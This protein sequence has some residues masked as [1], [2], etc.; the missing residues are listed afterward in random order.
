MLGTHID[1]V[2]SGRVSAPSAVCSIRCSRRAESNHA[3]ARTRSTRVSAEGD[4][5]NV[6]RSAAKSGSEATRAF[7]SQRPRTRSST[8]ERRL[9]WSLRQTAQQPSK[10]PSNIMAPIPHQGE[11]AAIPKAW[12]LSRERDLQEIP[13]QR[14]PPRLRQVPKNPKFE[15]SMFSRSDAAGSQPATGAAPNPYRP[16]RPDRDRNTYEHPQYRK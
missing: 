16:D 5:V 13:G 4:S 15:S 1:R 7:R 3:R 10:P 11:S 9:H 12:P 6:I 14:V 8:R 2:D